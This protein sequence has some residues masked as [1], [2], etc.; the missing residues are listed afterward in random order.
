MYTINFIPIVNHKYLIFNFVLDTNMQNIRKALGLTRRII[1]TLRVNSNPVHR[2]VRDL[3]NFTSIAPDV[4]WFCTPPETAKP[5]T[6]IPLGKIEEHRMLLRFTCKICNHVNNK[7]ISKQAYTNGVVI[8]R[9]DG[10]SNN[11]LIADNLNW[12]TD[13]NGKKNIEDILAEKGETVTRLSLDQ[14]DVLQIID[15]KD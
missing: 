13:L 12:F 6:R 14:D 8:V 1:G 15:K 9:C 5:D 2:A 7:G 10:C 3:P 11:H 4:R